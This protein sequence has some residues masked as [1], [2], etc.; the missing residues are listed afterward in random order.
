V[1]ETKSGAG[2]DSRML[3]CLGS[4]LSPKGVDHVSREPIN[5]DV[6]VFNEGCLEKGHLQ[7]NRPDDTA[8][9]LKKDENVLIIKTNG[10]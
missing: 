1:A 5:K 10:S 4:M 9:C 7:A 6:F 8:S 2:W 3:C